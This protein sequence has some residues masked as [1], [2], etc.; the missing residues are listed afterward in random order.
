MRSMRSITLTSAGL[1]GSRARPYSGRQIP[2]YRQGRCSYQLSIVSEK[3]RVIE[4]KFIRQVKE[5]YNVLQNKMKQKF[6]RHVSFGD[7]F[8]DRWE[9]SRHSNLSTGKKWQR[10]S[11]R[12]KKRATIIL[13]QPPAQARNRNL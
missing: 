3:G 6:N 7:L 8:T 11:C 9:T 12:F 2:P 5:A 4:E 13:L 10:H 1:S